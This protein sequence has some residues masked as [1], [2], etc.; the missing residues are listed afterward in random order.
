MK[1]TAYNIFHSLCQDGNSRARRSVGRFPFNP[2][3]INIIISVLYF[4]VQQFIPFFIQ[5]Y[6]KML[7]M[8]TKNEELLNHQKRG[9]INYPAYVVAATCW[10][11]ENR[12]HVNYRIQKYHKPK[13][14]N[15]S[16]GDFYF[17]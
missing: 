8:K 13:A 10:D 7:D 17:L 3:S 16:C 9:E 2:S 15:N 6:N 1:T 14:N 4:E 5:S 11:F 12:D